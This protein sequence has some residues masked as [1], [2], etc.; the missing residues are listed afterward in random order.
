MLAADWT[1][2][3]ATKRLAELHRQAEGR[4][5]TRLARAHRRGGNLGPWR[6]RRCL[7]SPPRGRVAD[8]PATSTTP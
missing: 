3:F 8:V 2:L 1:A 7:V 5:L 6:G 4:R